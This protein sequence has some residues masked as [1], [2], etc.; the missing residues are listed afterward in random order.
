[1]A[2]NR[3]RE[4]SPLRTRLLD[5]AAELIVDRGFRRLHLTEVATR[6]GV[7]RQTVYNEFGSKEG[8]GQELFGRE[9]HRIAVGT[10][11]ELEANRGR[12]RAATEAGVGYI[13]HEAAVNPLLRAVLT[14]DRDGENG[15]LAYLTTRSGAAFD[16]FSSLLVSYTEEV[17]PEVD[18]LS[19]SLAVE[20]V[21]RLTASHLLQSSADPAEAG[22]TEAAGRIAEIVMRVSGVVDPGPGCGPDSGPDSG[23]D[24]M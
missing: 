13:L 16:T 9:L 14:A 6:A 22:L 11:A 8:L 2:T 24:G 23:P 7:S 4:H 20:S 18:D 3:E 1:M 12:L 10:L 15:L 21:V 17:W 19:R 5:T